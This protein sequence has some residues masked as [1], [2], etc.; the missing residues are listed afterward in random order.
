MANELVN[1]DLTRDLAT[2]Y[3][4]PPDEFL[5]T[6]KAVCF[7]DGAASDAQLIVF[8]QHARHYGLN[9]LA[10]EIYAFVKNG[11]MSIGVQVDGW[12]RKAQEH[13]QF[14][15]FHFKD[16]V[17]DGKLVAVTC[18][19][20]RKDWSHPG[21]YTAYLAEWGRTTD[22]WKSMPRHQLAVKAF[23]QCCRFTLGMTGIYDPDDLERIAEHPVAHVTDNG[24]VED[25]HVVDESTGEVVGATP[26]PPEEE[27]KSPVPPTPAA[28][29]GGSPQPSSP[30]QD[31]APATKPTAEATP[32]KRGRPK[33]ARAR[34]AEL[35]KGLPK[36]RETVMLGQL[37]VAKWEELTDAQV[38]TTIERIEKRMGK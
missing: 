14:A 32:P 3:S 27:L 31:T 30:P 2:E 19:M 8:L 36:A 33:G 7:P 35:V 20:H 17:V 34:L 21:E 1:V 9:P 6:I 26:P 24:H 29:E 4:L 5:K 16:T 22:V 18:V 10:R 25:A 15:G 12:I 23:N 13:P 38:A 28:D 11:R 37:G